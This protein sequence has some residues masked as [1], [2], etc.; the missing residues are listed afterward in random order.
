VVQ[1][2]AQIAQGIGDAAAVVAVEG[3]VGGFGHGERQM[4]PAGGDGPPPTMPA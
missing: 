4:G 2:A 1:I 3:E